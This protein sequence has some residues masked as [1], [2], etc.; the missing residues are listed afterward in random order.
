M[1]L[2]LST[3]IL[4]C[5]TVT[6]L[7][8]C[9]TSALF[10]AELSL[11]FDDAVTFDLVPKRMEKPLNTQR[12]NTSKRNEAL[13]FF[14]QR[15]NID[16]TKTTPPAGFKLSSGSFEGYNVFGAV[17]KKSRFFGSPLIR[18]YVDV[19][20]VTAL[21]SNHTDPVTQKTIPKDA[22]AQFAYYSF[23]YRANNTQFTA[24]IKATS[25]RF[26]D[27]WRDSY[28]N[29]DYSRTIQFDLT[30]PE[31]GVG[32][33]TGAAFAPMH[34]KTLGKSQVSM[35]EFIRFPP[36]LFQYSNTGKV[37]TCQSWL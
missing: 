9:N 11:V 37:T 1:K 28:G 3:L 34:D 7:G 19:M 4:L 10:D 36:N 2:I 16:F 31:W 13:N 26:I 22:I 20:T 35:R 25:Q 27:G 15:F 8:T 6:I 17:T 23:F 33:S 30:S 5:L 29:L 18:V 14:K 32:S 21:D 24:P 12:F